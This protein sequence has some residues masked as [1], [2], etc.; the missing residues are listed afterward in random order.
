MA[1][2][3]RY[4]TPLTATHLAELAAIAAGES[5]KK[6]ATEERLSINTVKERRRELRAR[7]GAVNAPHAVALGYQRG[8]LQ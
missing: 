2:T 7:L 5:L 6:R 1:N 8:I 3:S 4:G